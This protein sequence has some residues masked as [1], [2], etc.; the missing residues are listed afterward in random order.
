[1]RQVNQRAELVARM[2]PDTIHPS[3]RSGAERRIFEVLKRAQGT[4]EWICLHSLALARHGYKRRCEIDFIVITRKAVLA[5][6]V[7][8]GRINRKE[9]V[10]EFTDRYGQ[11]YKRAESPFD[12]ASSG[13]FALE[14]LLRSHFGSENRLARLLLG[15]GVLLPDVEFDVTGC[16]VPREIVYDIRDARVPIQAYIE[17]LTAFTNSTQPKPKFAPTAKDASDLLAFLRGDFELL[18][19]LSVMG[20][21]SRQRMISLTEA[22]LAVLDVLADRRG[23]I[24]EG[25]AGTGKTLLAVETARREAR[26]GNRVLL[27]C[28]NRLLAASLAAELHKESVPSLLV[29]SGIH[30]F[31]EQLIDESSLKTEFA[32]IRKSIE[33]SE[34]WRQRYPEYAHLALIESGRP[35]FDVLVVDE[36]QDM[37]SQPLLDFWDA[38]LHGGLQAGRWRIF[39]DSNNQAA[40]YGGLDQEAMDRLRRFGTSHILTVNCR[41]T[42]QIVDETNM[43]AVPRQRAVSLNPGVPVEY[44]WYGDLSQ[45]SK[46]L[47]ALLDR[48]CEQGIKPRDV[49]V[50][51]A[52]KLDNSCT[53]GLPKGRLVTL[54]ADNI[55]EIVGSRNPC[56]TLSTVSAFKGLENNYVILTDIE[57]LESDWWRSVVY[58][59]MSRARLGLFVLIRESLKTSFNEKLKRWAI[60]LKSSHEGGGIA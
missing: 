49:T 33:G 15:Y 4:E 6:E 41:N 24:V 17:R 51:S 53:S 2:I 13:M 43:L 56:P 46:K 32:E 54:S 47:L 16:D 12:Q 48:L 22:Q 39:L 45:G 37:L 52:R 59:G 55:K 11:V 9:G 25:A 10:W 36:G 58:V 42:K 57:E 23:I 35:P 3:V 60:D 8:G 1:M 19:P 34:L 50:L 5:L 26:I 20:E 21:D 14:K 31:L 18:P 29:V 28:F 7:K 44:I 38:C 27:L 40:L 30:Q